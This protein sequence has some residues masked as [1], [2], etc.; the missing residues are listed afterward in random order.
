MHCA[1]SIL[2]WYKTRQWFF[3]TPSLQCT[4]HSP[5]WYGTKQDSKFRHPVAMRCAFST[6]QYGT[7]Q[8]SDSWHPVAMRCAFSTLVRYKTYWYFST[9]SQC[10]VH[11]PLKYN[12]KQD[13]DVLS[14]RRNALCILHCTT[15]N[16]LSS[17]QW[18]T[19]HCPLM[20]YT[21]QTTITSA[22]R[23]NALCS[24]LSRFHRTEQVFCT[25]TE[26]LNQ[27]GANIPL[28]RSRGAMQN[29][30]TNCE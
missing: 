11:S 12:T 23:R 15:D 22:P 26:G 18:Y 28:W 17:P 10:V 3:G 9:P 2:W 20:D 4:V 14:P 7:K 29:Q 5:L 24:F 25:S 21:G 6:F 16:N 1:F 30:H 8:D 27:S 19:V 13:S